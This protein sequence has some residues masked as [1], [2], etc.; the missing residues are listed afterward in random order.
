M[1]RRK[2]IEVVPNTGDGALDPGE[3]MELPPH[4]RLTEEEWKQVRKE[5]EADPVWGR[6]LREGTKD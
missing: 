6:P 5:A 4:L 1:P 3:M 2:F